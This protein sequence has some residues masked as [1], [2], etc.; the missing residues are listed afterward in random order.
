MKPR[1]WFK[2]G[3]GQSTPPI[4]TSVSVSTATTT[5]NTTTSSSNPTPTAPRANDEFTFEDVLQNTSTVCDV[6]RSVGEASE[7]LAPLKAIF[8]ALKIAADTAVVG[9][10]LQCLIEL[11]RVSF[12]QLVHKN[13]ADLQ[14]VIDKLNRH[15]NLIEDELKELSNPDFSKSKDVQGLLGPLNAYTLY[16]GVLLASLGA[17]IGQKLAGSI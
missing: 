11:T 16:V 10:S 12:T 4:S 1:N 15:K 9:H 6:I 2:K 14:D 8:G 17:D 5:S 7:L 3:K 13:G